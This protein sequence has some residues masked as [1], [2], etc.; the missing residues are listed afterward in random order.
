MADSIEKIATIGQEQAASIQYTSTFIEE[1]NQM[2]QKLH[3]FANR[4]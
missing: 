3:E 4:L 2:S 1:I